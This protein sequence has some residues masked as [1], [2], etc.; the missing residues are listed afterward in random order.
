MGS[1]GGLSGGPVYDE[2]G[3]VRGVIV[4]KFLPVHNDLALDLHVPS[5]AS[6]AAISRRAINQRRSFIRV[7][8]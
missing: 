5:F 6:G 7:A 8:L 3:N 2:N 1:L 4:A